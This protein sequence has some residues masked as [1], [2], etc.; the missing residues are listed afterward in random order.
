MM[1]LVPPAVGPFWILMDRIAGSARTSTVSHSTDP[2]MPFTRAIKVGAQAI[3][4]VA[5]ADASATVALVAGTGGRRN[6]RVDR[7]RA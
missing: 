4:G 7:G 1:M 2:G 6:R 3:V 5:R